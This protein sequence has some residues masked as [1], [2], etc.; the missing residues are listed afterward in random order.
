MAGPSPLATMGRMTILGVLLMIQGF[1]ALVAVH[2]FDRDFGLLHLVFDGGALTAAGI[3]TGV[4]G[5]A[6]TV[7]GI[8]HG[9]E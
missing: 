7:A 8:V 3:V 6:L 5:L 1:G 2:F 4:L 9:D